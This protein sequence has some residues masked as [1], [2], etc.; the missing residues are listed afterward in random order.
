LPSRAYLLQLHQHAAPA[1]FAAGRRL[2]MARILV[3]EDEPDLLA[4]LSDQLSM[5]GHEVLVATD[6]LQGLRLARENRPDLLLTDVIMPFMDGAEML[7]QIRSHDETRHLP[8]IAF[9]ALTDKRTQAR[10]ESLG[11]NSFLPKPYSF[12]EL[13][14]RIQEA[15]RSTR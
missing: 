7:E 5:L 9:S 3:V 4:L 10:L 15:T 8:V 11:I 13:E 6:G 12:Q 2:K 1:A 14:E